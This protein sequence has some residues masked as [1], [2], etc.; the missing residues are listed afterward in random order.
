MKVTAGAMKGMLKYAD[1]GVVPGNSTVGDKLFARVNSGEVVLNKDQQKSALSQMENGGVSV[2]VQI[3]NNTDSS[4][5]TSQDS[6][7]NIK[8][9]IESVIVDTMSNNK[10]ASIMKNIYGVKKVGN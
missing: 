8:V 7:G 4:V 3:I 9:L 5:S 10:G 1:G 6:Q 2:N